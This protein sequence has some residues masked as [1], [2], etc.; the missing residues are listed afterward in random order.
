VFD[1]GEHG[2]PLFGHPAAV[3]AQRR[4]PRLVP[5]KVFR[6]DSIEALI[7]TISQ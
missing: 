4:S 5:A 2:Q 6:H 1:G 7:M 3:G